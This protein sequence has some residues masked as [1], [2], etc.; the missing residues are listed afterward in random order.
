MMFIAVDEGLQSEGKT[1]TRIIV[2]GSKEF[3]VWS[4]NTELGHDQ[5]DEN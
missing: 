3:W 5:H 4:T 1:V 2:I